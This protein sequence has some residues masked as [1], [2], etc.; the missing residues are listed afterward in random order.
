MRPKLLWFPIVLAVP[1]DLSAS[2]SGHEKPKIAA[3]RSAQFDAGG[4][5]ILS[6]DELLPN[7]VAHQSGGRMQVE[8]EHDP[9]A[10]SFHSPGA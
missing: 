1:L 4:G 5:E 6:F 2:A 3:S 8:F 10:I 7:R 9:G